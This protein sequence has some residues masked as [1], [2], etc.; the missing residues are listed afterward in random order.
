MV[1]LPTIP[2]EGLYN[3]R[4]KTHIERKNIT[5]SNTGNPVHTKQANLMN[6]EILGLR[7]PGTF[8]ALRASRTRR[9]HSLLARGQSERAISRARQA[10]APTHM[11]V[12]QKAVDKLRRA[13]R[14]LFRDHP[15]CLY[16][17]LWVW[18]GSSDSS[19]SGTNDIWNSDK[20]LP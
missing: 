2:R 8:R 12:M 11:H 5:Q 6:I 19:D 15:K 4:H 3:T 14:A 20:T 7:A 18:G 10:V 13:I 1:G 9:T 16:P 17:A